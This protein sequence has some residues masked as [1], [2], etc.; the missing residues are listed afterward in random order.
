MSEVNGSLLYRHRWGQAQVRLVNRR[1]ELRVI[2]DYARCGF[3][4]T[5]VYGFWIPRREFQALSLLSSID[6]FPELPEYNGMFTVSYR[7]VEGHPI[8]EGGG[9]SA[10]S[11]CFFPHL[12]EMMKRMHNSGLVHLDLGNKGNVLVRTDGEP[13][14][15]DLASCITTRYFPSFLVRWLRTRDKL[16]VL[17][18][19][20]HYSPETLPSGLRSFYE[21]RYRKSIHTPGRLFRATN[22]CIHKGQWNDGGCERVRRAWIIIGLFGSVLAL[23]GLSAR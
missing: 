10:L 18:L 20:N 9:H 3:P 8:R 21:R 22:K 2:K 6:G 5:L 11:P 19:W 7:Y 16:G 15:I 4:G 12:W 17:K 23:L 1:G 14:I 13:A